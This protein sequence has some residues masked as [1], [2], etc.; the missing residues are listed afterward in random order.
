M[1]SKR[2][3][4]ADLRIVVSTHIGA[5][6]GKLGTANTTADISSFK[7]AEAHVPHVF[8]LQNGA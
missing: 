7:L 2:I 8:L 6:G 1:T 5:S 3:A 4:R